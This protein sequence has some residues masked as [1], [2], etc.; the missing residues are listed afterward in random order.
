MLTSLVP[1]L[2]RASALVF[3]DFTECDPGPDG[4]S[5]LDVIRDI[6]QRLTIPVWIGAP[7]GHGPRNRPFIL[8]A[9]ARISGDVLSCADTA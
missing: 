4:V 9:K 2:S 1:Q 6:A 7:F 8:G 3:G 5:A